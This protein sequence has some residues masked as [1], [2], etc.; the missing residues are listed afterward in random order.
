[1]RRACIV[2][3]QHLVRHLS[4]ADESARLAWLRGDRFAQHHDRL[5]QGAPDG[6]VD[7]RQFFFGP[8]CAL[9][10]DDRVAIERNGLMNQ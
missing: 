8:D 5:V 3:G 1:M 4:G 6:D 9:C 2:S 10:T 7:H